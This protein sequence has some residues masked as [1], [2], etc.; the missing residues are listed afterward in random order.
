MKIGIYQDANVNVLGGAEFVIAVMAHSLRAQ[1]EV[2]IV[3]HR[4]HCT[5][6]ELGAYFQINLDGVN[7]RFCP[8]EDLKWFDQSC[9]LWQKKSKVA[10]AFARL[11][12][13]YDLFIALSH[14]IPPYCYS[15]RGLV[16]VLFPAFNRQ[17]SWP[18]NQ[19][20]SLSPK[21]ILNDFRK[22]V[23]EHR[24]QA[25]LRSYDQFLAIS[26]FTAFWTDQFW[27]KRCTILPP[28]VECCFSPGQKSNQIIT[29]GRFTQVKKQK[30]L[31]AAFSKSH[32]SKLFGW[33]MT[34]LGGLSDDVRDHD[35]IKELHLLAGSSPVQLVTNASRE[36]VRLELEQAK[37]FWHGMG[38]GENEKIDPFQLEHF[39]IATVEA[40]AAGCVPIVINK[41]GQ[42]EIVEHGQ[43]GFLCNDVEEMVEYT[44]RLVRDDNLLNRLSTAARSR[45]SVFSK[46]QFMSR[47]MQQVQSLMH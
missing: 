34:C 32:L 13:P 40:M 10:G 31:V 5:A 47:F 18:W 21:G 24:W 6:R 20:S 33:R 45:A 4:T 3:Q 1:H 37:V 29:L 44:Y 36:K 46:E 8:P 7:S 14:R 25:H 19:S 16:Y 2:E 15:K 30:E 41:G 17:M 43:S 9:H 39:G 38:L 11:S 22:R 27:G 35:Y 23:Y 26:E 42:R 12:E 28:P